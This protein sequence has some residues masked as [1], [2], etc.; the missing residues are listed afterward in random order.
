MALL[1]FASGFWTIW[2]QSNAF[3]LSTI[4]QRKAAGEGDG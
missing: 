4:G 3:S 2:N 1:G